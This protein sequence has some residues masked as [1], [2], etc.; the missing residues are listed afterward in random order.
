MSE[1]RKIYQLEGKITIVTESVTIERK[2]GNPFNKRTI[3]VVTDEKQVVFF[4]SRKDLN[5]QWQIG[6]KVKINYYFAGSFKADKIYNNVIASKII[7]NE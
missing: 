1:N 3:G 4:E 5:V 2:D 6:D 7:S